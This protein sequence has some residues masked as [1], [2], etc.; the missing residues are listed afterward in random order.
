M[1]TAIAARISLSNDNRLVKQYNDDNISF[2]QHIE[3]NGRLRS[4]EKLLWL[5]VVHV[6]LA[7]LPADCWRPMDTTSP[8]IVAVT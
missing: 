3:A 2:N 5:P 1:S 6:V 4:W 7:P 8:L